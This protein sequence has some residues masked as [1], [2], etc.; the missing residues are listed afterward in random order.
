M[1]TPLE[2]AI[3]HRRDGKYEQAHAILRELLTKDPNDPAVLYQMAW[4]HDV[5]GLERDAVPYYEAA[6][7]H[8]LSG[9]DLRGALL[10]LGSTYRALGDY[11]RAVEVLRRGM[12][13][14]P[15]ALEFAAFLAM[16]LYNT[17]QHS[18]AM[19]L[20]LKT[21]A[22]TSADEGIRRFGRAILFYHDKLDQ[23]WD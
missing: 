21:L 8:G 12:A 13:A 7:A 5:Q 18:E 6:L 22:E 2:Q 19:A 10:G 23:R 17:G 3:R 1:Q 11:D 4:L 15:D 16:A 9:E 20:L 14:F